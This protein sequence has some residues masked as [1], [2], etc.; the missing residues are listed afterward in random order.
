MESAILELEESIW[1]INR[2]GREDVEAGPGK[3][4]REGADVWLPGSKA[5][6]SSDQQHHLKVEIID[7]SKA[8]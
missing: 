3:S 8:L 2:C 7:G 6:C 1:I 4:G 5:A